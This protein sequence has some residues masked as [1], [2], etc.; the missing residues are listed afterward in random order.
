MPRSGYTALPDTNDGVQPTPPPTT[1]TPQRE[2]DPASVTATSSSIAGDRDGVH[3]NLPIADPQDGSNFAEVAGSPT[4]P[5]ASGGKSTGGGRKRNTT[6]GAEP[7]KPREDGARADRTSGSAAG[8]A[9]AGGKGAKGGREKEADVD[10]T[11]GL[12]TTEG[13]YV[14]TPVVPGVQQAMPRMPRSV[15]PHT[16]ATI[17]QTQPDGTTHILGQ[18]QLL[19][20]NGPGMVVVCTH[21]QIGGYVSDVISRR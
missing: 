10:L 6:E 21:R 1:T 8:G 2:T 15:P 3:E 7:G 16:A 19:Y 9:A 17:L 5:A 11:G 13:V 4:A 20:Q 12:P 18:S 14:G